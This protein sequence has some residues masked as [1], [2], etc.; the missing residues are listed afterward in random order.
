MCHLYFFDN[1]VDGK[2]YAFGFE[3][4]KL[5]NFSILSRRMLKRTIW[6]KIEI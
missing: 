1:M 2:L 3:T 5:G 6:F 4:K